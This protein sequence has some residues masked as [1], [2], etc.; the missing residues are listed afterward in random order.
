[1]NARLEFVNILLLILLCQF[2]CISDVDKERFTYY[3]K[4]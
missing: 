4:K 1:M 2:N 3:A